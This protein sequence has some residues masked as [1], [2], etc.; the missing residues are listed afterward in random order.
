MYIYALRR[1]RINLRMR[2][3]LSEFAFFRF[4]LQGLEVIFVK[5][6]ACARSDLSSRCLRMRYDSILRVTLNIIRVL[7][8]CK[9]CHTKTCLRAYAESEDPDQPAHPRSLIRA[10]I[11]R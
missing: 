3:V 7:I 9:P 6:A 8:L 11:V 5:R 10:F 4:K 1:H 2:A